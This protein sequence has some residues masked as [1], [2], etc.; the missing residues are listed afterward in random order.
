MPHQAVAALKVFSDTAL[1]RGRGGSFSLA[2]IADAIDE[3]FG[4]RPGSVD[5]DRN[6]F[7]FMAFPVPMR[8]DVEGR[9]LTVPDAAI[10]PVAV[11]RDGGEV[12]DAE[13]GAVVGPG[14]LVVGAR[15][16]EIVETC[17]D[18]LSE[19]PFIV[20]RKGEIYVGDIGP[21]AGIQ[22]VGGAMVVGIDGTETLFCRQLVHATGADGRSGF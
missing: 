13:H 8:E 9:G 12:Y 11:L 3:E 4:F 15:L 14:I 18:E 17:P 10:E 7:A 6:L 19:G 5:E 1:C 20:I 21:G 16:A 22:I 2:A